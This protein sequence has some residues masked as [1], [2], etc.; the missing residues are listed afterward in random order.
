MLVRKLLCQTICV[1]K[2]IIIPDN[3]KEIMK[4]ELTI[5]PEDL[6]NTVLQMKLEKQQG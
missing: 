5:L 6:A 3:R 2:L 4:L 1:S